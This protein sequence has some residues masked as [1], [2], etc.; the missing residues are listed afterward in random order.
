MLSRLRPIAILCLLALSATAL[1]AQEPAPD[2]KRVDA[3]REY[4]QALLTS[5]K[6]NA[7]ERRD[8]E[9]RLRD[10][11]FQTGDRIRLVVLGDTA[12]SDTFTV[13]PG[14]ILQ[15]PNIPDIAL[16]GVL[17]SEFQSFIKTK[18]TQYLR[19][20]QVTAT[21]LVRLAVVGEVNRP[22]FYVVPAT[23]LASDVVMAAGGPS[24]RA[25]IAKTTVRRGTVPVID[26]K[27]MRQAYADGVSIDQ[28]NLHSGDEFVVGEKS[29]GIKGALQTAGLISGIIVG[30]VALSRL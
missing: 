24:G 17:R 21:P 4:L 20:P 30:L 12:L 22:G 10:G 25:D 7:Q 3:S 6:L 19:D 14:R 16:Q 26:P 15:L 28:L 8:V 18:L 27:Q 2:A 1:R 23:T 13:R 9:T 11:D 5:G 29:G